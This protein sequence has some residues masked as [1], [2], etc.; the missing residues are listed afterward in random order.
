MLPLGDLSRV[1]NIMEH[2]QHSTFAQLTGM[3][4]L[5]AWQLG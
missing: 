2:I 5:N 4:N 3:Q 1:C